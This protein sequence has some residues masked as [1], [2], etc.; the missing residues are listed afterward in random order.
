MHIPARARTTGSGNGQWW[1][2]EEG[3]IALCG[4]PMGQRGKVAHKHKLLYFT[5]NISGL[6]SDFTLKCNE[7]KCNVN[8]MKKGTNLNISLHAFKRQI[9]NIC[10]QEI[11]NQLS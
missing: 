10:L 3:G 9:K 6:C 2:A 5:L 4:G 8:L 11:E 7:M 1:G